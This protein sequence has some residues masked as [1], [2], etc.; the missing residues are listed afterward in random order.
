MNFPAWTL[1]ALM[2]AAPVAAAP[3][4]APAEDLMV[5]S[6]LDLFFQIYDHA[7][8]KPDAAALE[9][10]LEYGSAGVEGFIPGRID[11]AENLARVIAAEPGVYAAARTCAKNLG[12]LAARVRAARQALADLDPSSR[13]VTVYLLIGANNSGGTADQDQLMLGLEVLCTPPVPSDVPLDVRLTRIIAHEMTHALQT[14]FAD[15]TVL[16]FS[17]NEGVPE[18][19]AELTTG[20]IFNAHLLD[21]TKGRE[22]EIERRF[23]AE[24]NGADFSPWLYNGAGTPE[25]PG[26]LGYWVG[27]RIAKSY[28]DRAPDKHAAIIHMLEATDA[29]AFLAESG[30][31]PAAPQPTP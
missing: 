5:T 6:D 9:A 23:T 25:A 29:K 11:S 15:Q 26:D 27:Y 20:S 18:L 22:A 10:Y 16:G 19:I 17:L 3:V 1:A 2:A 13:F 7:N 28:Y 31:Q 24:M 8:G 4:R 14:G 30:W 12:G 21:W